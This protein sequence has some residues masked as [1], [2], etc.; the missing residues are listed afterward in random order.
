[1]QQNPPWHDSTKQPDL[2]QQDFLLPK[3]YPAQKDSHSVKLQPLPED[4]DIISKEIEKLSSL[5]SG[6]FG[7]VWKCRWNGSG[8]GQIV[9]VKHFSK[10]V[11]TSLKKE[12]SILR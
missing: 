9:A 8:G 7:E 12:V 1:M 4:A 5:G 3:Q 11:V 2:P 6:S 10:E